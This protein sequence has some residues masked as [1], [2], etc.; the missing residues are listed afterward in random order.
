MERL[1]TVWEKDGE[2]YTSTACMWI[3]GRVDEFRG[4]VEVVE[5]CFG[6]G[7]SFG[8]R[9]WDPMD[10]ECIPHIPVDDLYT[11]PKDDAPT[12]VGEVEGDYNSKLAQKITRSLLV[13]RRE[14]EE[15]PDSYMKFVKSLDDPL[16]LS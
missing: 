9:L 10:P 7:Q 3:G 8:L 14:E 5:D 15:E 12:W 6:D 13:R 2:F 4:E 1:T 11:G 16:C